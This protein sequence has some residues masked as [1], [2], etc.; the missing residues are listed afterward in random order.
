MEE[1]VV[2]RLE[3]GSGFWNPAQGV[4]REKGLELKQLPPHGEPGWL[5]LQG[6]LPLLRP[7]SPPRLAVANRWRL[8]RFC[9]NPDGGVRTFV[10]RFDLDGIPHFCRRRR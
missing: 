4:L 9:C 3:L 6:S 1:A 7:P 8:N 5:L 2:V 10:F